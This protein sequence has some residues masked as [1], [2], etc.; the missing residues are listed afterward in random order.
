DE[1]IN[2][3]AEFPTDYGVLKINSARYE[4]GR[5]YLGY[6]LD[7]KNQ[8][9]KIRN[10]SYSNS[11]DIIYN[12]FPR[13]SLKDAKNNILYSNERYSAPDG[14]S[15]ELYFTGK[16]EA[17]DKPV[18]VSINCSEKLA[19]WKLP[20]KIFR[21]V[22]KT[23]K[24]DRKYN[25]EGGTLKIKNLYL[26]SATSYLDYIFTPDKDSDITGI[27]PFISA[28]TK[29]K[30]YRMTL[31]N[32]S[33]S[34]KLLWMYPLNSA[35]INNTKFKLF[36]IYRTVKYDKTVALDSKNIPSSFDI[37]G[38]TIRINSMEAK[39]G[40]VKIEL[41]LKDSRRKFYDFD[42][43]IK[44]H[45]A[46]TAVTITSSVDFENPSVEEKFKNNPDLITKE[47]MMNT[48]VKK[49]IEFDGEIENATLSINSLIYADIYN[50]EIRIK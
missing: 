35:D 29:D 38:T 28:K 14:N 30:K 3:S 23:I 47:D 49:T 42:I 46:H 7:L 16:L 34:G 17:L 26:G 27:Q 15:G 32:N 33:L 6:K 22:A 20:V 8:I 43:G 24:V 45:N 4:K 40:K 10:S 18:T 5:L 13:I 2:V 9:N 48:T 19:D 41:E 11:N 1:K 39:A 37:D 50:K 31:E 21:P 36:A 25:L 44:N 12:F